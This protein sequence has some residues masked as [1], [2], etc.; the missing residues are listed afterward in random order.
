VISGI[1]IGASAYL[2]GLAA[3]SAADAFAETGKGFTN[4][5]MV[6]GVVETIAIFVMAFSIVLLGSC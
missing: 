6:L 2:Q 5:L 3:A 4:Q 1:A